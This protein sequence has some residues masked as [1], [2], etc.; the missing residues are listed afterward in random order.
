MEFPIIR[1]QKFP[2]RGWAK[3]RTLDPQSSCRSPRCYGDF[4]LAFFAKFLGNTME[5][6]TESVQDLKN[7]GEIDVYGTRVYWQYTPHVIATAIRWLETFLATFPPIWRKCDMTWPA[8]CLD[9]NDSPTWK[10]RSFGDSPNP[11]PIIPVVENG[12]RSL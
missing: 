1:S 4:H 7:T 9:Y 2:W 6:P 8:D 10:V 3:P 12:V 5:N 11:T